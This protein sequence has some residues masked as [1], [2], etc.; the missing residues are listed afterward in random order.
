MCKTIY[1][2]CIIEWRS[3]QIKYV[4]RMKFYGIMFVLH[5]GHKKLIKNSL[6]VSG[7]FLLLLFEFVGG[8]MVKA[9]IFSWW[10]FS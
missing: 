7:F 3:K 8:N 5:V 9:A 2:Q 4:V 6:T 1:L 10:D